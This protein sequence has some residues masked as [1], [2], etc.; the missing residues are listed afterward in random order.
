MG[1]EMCIRD[2]NRHTDESIT[3]K[4]KNAVTKEMRNAG[5]DASAAKEWD[6]LISEKLKKVD[7]ELDKAKA[8][9][10]ASA[11]RPRPSSTGN[12]RDESQSYWDARRC[13]RIS[14]VPGTGKD[15]WTG[16]EDFFFQKMNIPR[17]QLLHKHVIHIERV[18]A[19]RRSKIKDEVLVT[20]SS[21]RIRDMVALSLIHI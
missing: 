12:Q 3:A 21:V 1:S 16:A 2:S 18:N 14:P 4:V 10:S 7:V 17:T 19:G 15:L 9:A 5:V 6:R 11:L 20:F 13:A 8:I